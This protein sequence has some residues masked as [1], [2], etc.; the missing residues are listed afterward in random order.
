[1]AQPCIDELVTWIIASN[2]SRIHIPRKYPV[3]NNLTF[4]LLV[5]RHLGIL[6]SLQ[7]LTQSGVHHPGLWTKAWVMN[8]KQASCL[9]SKLSMPTVVA[10]N[11]N[12]HGYDMNSEWYTLNTNWFR[13]PWV[14]IYSAF[15]KW[16]C[17]KMVLL[18][19]S[20][21]TIQTLKV[22]IN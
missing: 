12:N 19:N 3:Q 21:I 8:E 14:M 16:T 5:L 6:V 9:R 10:L 13:K 2:L 22:T 11:S 7:L 15:N 4:Y 1:M 17:W 20:T 18:S